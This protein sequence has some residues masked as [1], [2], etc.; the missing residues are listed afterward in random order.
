[1]HFM[2]V[3]PVELKYSTL[4][5]E[6]DFVHIKYSPFHLFKAEKIVR[7]GCM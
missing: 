1:M 3:N 2:L 6:V 7:L 5:L 4:S